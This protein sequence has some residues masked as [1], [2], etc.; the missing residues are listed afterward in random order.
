[1]RKFLATLALV[2][3]LVCP[4]PVH[5]EEAP[6]PDQPAV[7]APAEA[8]APAEKHAEDKAP[9]VTGEEL[10]DAGAKALE[11]VKEILKAPKTGDWKQDYLYPVITLLVGIL[12]A[13]AS[14]AG[15]RHG[16]PYLKAKA[17][18]AG[19]ELDE[20]KER[21]ISEIFKDAVILAEATGLQNL[22]GGGQTSGE[23]KAIEAKATI[24]KRVAVLGIDLLEDFITGKL[25]DTHAVLAAD[26]KSTVNAKKS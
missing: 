2:A 8:P 5:A 13:L 4:L 14:A 10:K 12:L 16:M 1:M 17:A 26:P 9:I 6:A 21:Q 23:Q 22:K 19:I 7:T 15:L 18:K 20:A 11:G 24:K 25:G 3:A